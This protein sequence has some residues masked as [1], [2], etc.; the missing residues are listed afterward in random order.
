[1]SVFVSCGVAAS[2]WCAMDKNSDKVSEDARRAKAYAAMK[3]QRVVV[4]EAKVRSRRELVRAKRLAT[5]VMLTRAELS[6]VIDL[7]RPVR[8]LKYVSDFLM[9]VQDARLSLELK[10]LEAN[11]KDEAIACDRDGTV[12]PG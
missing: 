6:A 12:F 7:L 4:C 1:M 9:K 11:R 10:M 5:T 3:A 8:S 2:A